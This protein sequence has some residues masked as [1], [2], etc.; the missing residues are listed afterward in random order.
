M[1]LLNNWGRGFNG[2]LDKAKG[3]SLLFYANDA[4]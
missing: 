3:V 4:G 1:G 2:E